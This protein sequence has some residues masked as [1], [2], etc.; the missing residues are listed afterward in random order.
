[1]SAFLG[2]IHFWMYNKIQVQQQIVEDLIEFSKE[3][4]PGLKAELDN[5][6]GE[7]ETRPLEEVI[8][9]G[10]I[11]GWLQSKVTQVEYKLAFTVT[12]L[13]K[14]KEDN[15]AKIHEIFEDN[16]K[17]IASAVTLSSA[18]QAF[19]LMND[20]L[21]DGMPCDHVNSLI[22]E[23]NEETV[24]KKNSC[25]HSSYWEQVGGNV[26]T[27]YQLRDGYIA[28]LLHGSSFVYEK[29]DQNTNRIVKA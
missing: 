22:K 2:P 17:K 11:H 1:M 25:V 24:W 5:L 20:S 4:L 26:D 13:L 12:E 28:G 18:T 7:S 8:D 16:G 3:T 14:N 15:F 6:Y 23:S 27:F 29:I 10:N 21:L 19:K 9:E